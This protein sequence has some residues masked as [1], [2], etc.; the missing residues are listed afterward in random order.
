[1]AGLA[2]AGETAAPGGTSP[3]LPRQAGGGAKCSPIGMATGPPPATGKHES[4]EASRR[5][6]KE[7]AGRPAA[8]VLPCSRAAARAHR[9]SGWLVGSVRAADWRSP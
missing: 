4:A 6:A 2:V 7:E 8:R 5:E 1:M 3:L 9:D